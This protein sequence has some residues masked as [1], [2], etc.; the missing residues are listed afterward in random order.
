LS[1]SDGP[2]FA[3]TL[4]R[5][6]LAGE[7]SCTVVPVTYTKIGGSPRPTAPYAVRPSVPN[8]RLLAYAA[9]LSS[10]R[11]SGI[12]VARLLGRSTNLFDGRLTW[13]GDGRELV[14]VP[15]EDAIATSSTA[16]RQAR[17]QPRSCSA[18]TARALCLIVVSVTPRGRPRAAHIVVVGAEPG[19][20][21][22]IAGAPTVPHALLIG[23]QLERRTVIDEISLASAR[24]RVS[25][26]LSLA[27]VLPVAFDQ[28]GDHLLYVVGHE[29][30][31]LWVARLAR[32]RLRDAHRLIAD[33]QLSAAAW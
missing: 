29:T 17:G 24:P 8:G 20:P 31:A 7:R 4:T 3:S 15:A 27:P 11:T 9:G 12:D 19:G 30:P 5:R 14:A 10:G 1:V 25:R 13:L 28:R 23:A 26:L 16:R 22:T 33:E 2:K 18:V 6:P 32:G 21:A